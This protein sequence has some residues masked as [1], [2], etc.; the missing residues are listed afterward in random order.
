[1]AKA[2]MVFLLIPQKP[3]FAGITRA[4]LPSTRAARAQTVAPAHEL[5]R[6]QFGGTS[7]PDAA[8]AGITQLDLE[9]VRQRTCRIG[10]DSCSP[11]RLKP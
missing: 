5:L 8:E 2:N 3:A 9:I 10:M 1:M 7:M 6:V 4:R 11:L